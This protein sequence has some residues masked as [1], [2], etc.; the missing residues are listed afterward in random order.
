MV[1]LRWSAVKLMPKRVIPGAGGGSVEAGDT[2]I[3]RKIVNA[4][5]PRVVSENSQAMRHT[6]LNGKLKG[7]VGRI[8]VLSVLLD[9]AKQVTG[10]DPQGSDDGIQPESSFCASRRK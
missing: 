2:S 5:G 1:K 6:F 9:L 8:D 3:R 7:V 4:L 10:S